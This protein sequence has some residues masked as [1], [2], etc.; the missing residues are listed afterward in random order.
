MPRIKSPIY[1]EKTRCQDCYKCIRECPVKAILV[2]KGH[3]IIIPEQCVLCGHCVVACPAQAK[4]VRDDLPQARQI[5]KLKPKVIASLAPSFAAVYPD[6]EPGQL[7][8][9]IK[10][11]GFYGVSETA[12][13]ADLVS[14]KIACDLSMAEDNPEA[15]PKD[16]RESLYGYRVQ[17]RS[18]E[19]AG[20]KPPLHRQKL[21]LSSACPVLVEF[22]KHYMPELS[23]SITDCAS[24]L[25]AHARYL[26][27]KY[28]EETGIVFIGPCIAKKREADT[29]D[30]LDAAISFTDLSRWLEDEGIRP[31]DYKAAKESFIPVKAAKGSL[32][33]IEGGMIASIRKYA[34]IRN[35]HMMSITG[36]K[37]IRKTLEGFNP[38]EFSAPIFMELLSCPGGCINGPGICD[39]T[40]RIFRRIRLLDYASKARNTLSEKLPCMQDTLPVERI[41]PVEHSEEEIQTALRQ[42]GKRTLQDALNCGSCGYDTCKAFAAA[43]LENRAEKT[44]CLSYMKTLAQNKAN[45][46]IRAIPAGVVICDSQLKIIECNRYFANMMGED[47]LSMFEVRPGMEGA[48]LEKITDLARYF[49]DVIDLNGLD[50][51]NREVREGK[52]IF[53]LTIFSIEKGESACGVLQDVTAPQ[54][55]KSRVIDETR[56]VINKNLKVVQKIAFLLGENAAETEA[57]LNSVIESFSGDEDSD[58]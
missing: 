31:A 10:A 28:G 34:S 33:P 5:L 32:Y 7:I 9:A 6:I 27:E 53:H 52:K 29:W 18:Q 3:A 13:G 43:M 41:V 2:E 44:M 19:A 57:I 35:V 11:L 4:K 54:I 48:S 49:K 58:L 39:D 40:Q 17:F 38:A 47:V 30:E 16:H 20:E 24:P 12:I 51:V 55:Q 56:R 22:I 25:L 15:D 1:T 26:K 36:L 42:I 37:E 46:L 14:A 50:L 21:F 45:G 8:S 23:P